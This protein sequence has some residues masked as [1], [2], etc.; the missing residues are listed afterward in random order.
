MVK[1][2]KLLEVEADE[3]GKC[4]NKYL[5]VRDDKEKAEEDLADAEETLIAALRKA[6]RQS[7]T[8]DGRVISIKHFDSRD[9]ISIKKV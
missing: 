4:A 7:I 3:V 8:L 2:A 1:Q 9:K 5:D 6:E